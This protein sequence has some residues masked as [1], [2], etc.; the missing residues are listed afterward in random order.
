[1]VRTPW[2]S[3]WLARVF[4]TLLTACSGH[5]PSILP[6]WPQLSVCSTVFQSKGWGQ[7]RESIMLEHTCEQLSAG[8]KSGL[9]A[10]DQKGGG[11]AAKDIHSFG[12]APGILP[13]WCQLCLAIFSGPVILEWKLCSK[14][15]CIRTACCPGFKCKLTMEYAGVCKAYAKHM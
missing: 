6:S 4:S 14:N 2:M 5:F 11:A 3:S 10:T 8:W 7:R 9:L 13:D 1:M 15:A 12:W